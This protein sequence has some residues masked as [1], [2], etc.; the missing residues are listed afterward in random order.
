MEGVLKGQKVRH[1]QT[2]YTFFMRILL[3]QPPWRHPS[4]GHVYNRA[5]LDQAR[6]Q[7]FPMQAWIWRAG[8]RPPSADLM[9][10]DS[11][12]LSDLAR[13]PLPAGVIHV[14][15]LHY[16]PSLDPGLSQSRRLAL[17]QLEQEVLARFKHVL[18]TGPGLVEPLR[19]RYPDRPFWLCEP[20]VSERFLSPLRRPVSSSARVELVTVANLLP[21]KGYLELLE[22][23]AGFGRHRWRWHW[24]GSGAVDPGYT[25][26]LRRAVRQLGLDGRIVHHGVLPVARLVELLDAADW[27]LFPSR[28][29]SF[30]MALQE[31]AARRLPIVSS[32]VGAAERWVIP[33]RTGFLLE[34]GDWSGFAQALRRCFDAPKPKAVWRLGY[35]GLPSPPTWEEVFRRWREIVEVLI[36]THGG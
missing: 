30:G 32:R 15:L 7:G 31:A 25:L 2:D 10:W 19:R 27:F 29:E 21:A 14:L 8:E 26:R 18:V 36:R 24:V 12:G 3:A 34:P 13:Q 17:K 1:S 33:K 16:L 5:L 23:L 35:R 20:G 22:V 28:F 11:L 9:F 4:G 6:R